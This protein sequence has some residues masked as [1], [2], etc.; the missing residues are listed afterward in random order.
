[1]SICARKRVVHRRKH[2]V[3]EIRLTANPGALWLN[4]A[5]GPIYDTEANFEAWEKLFSCVSLVES[6]PFSHWLDLRGGCDVELTAKRPLSDIGISKDT[7]GVYASRL[8]NL[9]QESKITTASAIEVVAEAQ[10]FLFR[11]LPP[12]IQGHAG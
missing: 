9:S 7:S 10:P 12:H 1:M 11:V 2:R 8:N 5:F 4:Q 3:A 6:G